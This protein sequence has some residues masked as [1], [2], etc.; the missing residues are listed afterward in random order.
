MKGIQGLVIAIVLGI[1]GAIF[2]WVYLSKGRDFEQD[3]FIGVP[4][5]TNID[6]GIPIQEEHLEEVKIPKPH[7]GNL[8]V[9]AY[10]WEDHATIIGRPTAR[11][12]E[13][14]EILLREDFRTAP[15]QLPL[16][17]NDAA[18]WIPIDTRTAIT[19]QIL[20]GSTRVSFSLPSPGS[21]NPLAPGSENWEWL[22]PFEVLSVGNRFGST[23]AMNASKTSPQHAH[24]LTLRAT[25][26]NGKP[27][28]KVTRLINHLRQTD[29]KPLRLQIHAPVSNP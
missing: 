13:G 24:M 6:R 27:D 17:D 4:K 11:K 7:V 22:G 14:G 19:S 12:Y 9:Y 8:K 26:K 16:K 28:V 21:G 5:G 1:I 15:D 10:P 20:P 18:V 25:R 23:E 2:N 29:Y 3:S